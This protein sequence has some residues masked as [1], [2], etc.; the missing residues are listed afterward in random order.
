MRGTLAIAAGFAT[1]VLVAMP[2]G[3]V[4][5]SDIYITGQV[6]SRVPGKNAST[7]RIAWDYKC[8]GEDGGSYG[9]TLKVL[10]TQP[11]PER[12]TTLGS[13]T[14]ERG[15]KT[16][17]LPPGRY[18]PKSDPYFCETERGQGFDKPEIGASFV[19][20]D[21]CGWT[22]SNV[23]GLVQHQHGTA[24]KAARPGSS[25]AQGDALVTPRRGRAVLRAVTGDGTTTLEGESVLRIDRKHCPAKAG[26]KVLLV[27]G[28]LTVA[29]P[30]DAPATASFL[31]TTG[32]ATVSGGPGARWNLEYAQRRTKVRALAG[33]VRVAGKVLKPGQTAK[34]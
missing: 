14:G 30:K 16:V 21:Y 22:V 15:S 5:S 12:T 4:P 11:E 24:V 28:G 26:W 9:W 10:R 3:A 8:L 32:N 23:R 19:V 1:A 7:V 31:T 18:L 2:A 34:I 13:G 33:K 27:E 29:V 20:P 25:V 6:L 17:Q